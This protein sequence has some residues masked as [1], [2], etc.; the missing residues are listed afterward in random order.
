MWMPLD[1]L[2]IKADGRLVAF[3]LI[4]NFSVVPFR[5][6]TKYFFFNPVDDVAKRHFCHTAMKQK[7]MLPGVTLLN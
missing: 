5:C 1:Q 7:G 2:E 4:E 6:S 3:L